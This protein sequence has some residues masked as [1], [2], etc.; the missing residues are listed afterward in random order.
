MTPK[1]RE[2]LATLASYLERLPADYKQFDMQT[3]CS[4]STRESEMEYL[5]HN[6]GL[7]HCGTVACAAGHGPAAGLLATEEEAKNAD[8]S[9]YRRRVFG[10]DPYL[11]WF[12][13]SGQWCFINN[14]AGGAAERVRYF[15][16]HG[17]P[18]DFKPYEPNTWHKEY[19]V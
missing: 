19:T 7:P 5:R 16:A 10:S 4:S 17:I 9:A 1:Q 8:W 3:Y 6:G 12:L 13:F 14:T 11:F 15:L 2:N 18:E